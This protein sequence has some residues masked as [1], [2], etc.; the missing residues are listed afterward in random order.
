MNKKT[1]YEIDEDNRIKT[2]IDLDFNNKDWFRTIKNIAPKTR[3]ELEKIQSSFDAK[4]YYDIIDKHI[5]FLK[6]EIV[7]DN[8][9]F[10][11]RYGDVLI[12]FYAHESCKF[13]VTF[14]RLHSSVRFQYDFLTSGFKYF[15][16]DVSCLPVAG[17][18]LHD[19]IIVNILNTPLKIVLLWGFLEQDYRSQFTAHCEFKSDKRSFYL[20]H[21]Q[22]YE[23]NAYVDI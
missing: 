7:V 17:L 2:N 5:S 9:K 15:I 11:P 18:Y 8:R 4:S 6:Q 1:K 13:D 12:G 19:G 23:K 16:D 14:D 21:G 3:I 22:I 20:N 10:L